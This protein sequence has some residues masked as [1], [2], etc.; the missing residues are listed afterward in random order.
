[1][2]LARGDKGRHYDSPVPSHDLAS[3]FH[4][5]RTDP[6]LAVLEGFHAIKHA[7]RFGADFEIVATRNRAALEGFAERL[8]PDVKGALA[9]L[10]IDVPGD[11]FDQLSP[12]PPDT[13]VIAIA[14]RRIIPLGEVIAPPLAAPIVL[15]ESPSHSGNI[16]AVIRAAAGAGAAA[17]VTTGPNDPWNPGAIRGSAGLHYALPVLRADAIDAGTRELIAIDPNGD[18]LASGLISQGAILAFGSERSGLSPELLAK[19]TRR[20]RIPMEPGVSS[21]NLATAVAV[22]L[23]AW[24]LGK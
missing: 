12:T 15:L 18:E 23:Y 5:A 3:R 20:I 24:R 17:V 21:L 22:T 6:A 8:A 10:A 9:E 16:G 14:R 1:L 19:A 2:Q 7:I 13:G 11:L 4:A